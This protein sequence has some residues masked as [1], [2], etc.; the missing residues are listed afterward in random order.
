MANIINTPKLL[1]AAGFAVGSTT[2]TTSTQ[3]YPNTGYVYTDPPKVVGAWK[4]IKAGKELSKAEDLTK[5][6]TYYQK[7]ADKNQISGFWSKTE[8]GAYVYDM[9]LKRVEDGK[10]S[11]QPFVPSPVNGTITLVGFYTNKADSAIH[12]KS[13]SDGK[14]YKLL[15]TDVNNA[16]VKR[17]DKVKAGQL[18]ARQAAFMYT[19]VK[20]S[21]KQ[22]NAN[23]HLHIQ[24]PSK[25][26]LQDY[27]I[28]MVN[29]S[30]PT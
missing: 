17:G 5:H 30:F 10:E 27:I 3:S 26:V 16:L 13:K 24:F 1:Q 21:G 7:E 4:V 6:H 22:F 12:I 8:S 28:N 23:I 15:H 19:G 29:D 20:K 11:T 2:S 14:T 9:V 25:K 18:L